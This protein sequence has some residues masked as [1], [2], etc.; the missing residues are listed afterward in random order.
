VLSLPVSRMV[1][2]MLTKSDNI[3][4]EAMARQVALARG[5]PASFDGGAQATREVLAELKLPVDGFGLIDGSGLSYNDHV[6]AQ[7]LTS[8]LAEAAS[9]QHADLRAIISGLPVAG[10]SGTLNKRYGANGT[11]AAAGIV[12]AKTGTLRSV[13]SLAGVA[14]DADGRLLAFSILADATPGTAPDPAEAA[15][16]RIAATLAGCGCG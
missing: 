8:V 15:L 3:V 2:T 1:E 7:L 12:R 10:W 5:K 4:A 9:P 14:V 16:D 6:T 13:N 11:A